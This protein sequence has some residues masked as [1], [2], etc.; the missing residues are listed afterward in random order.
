MT[1]VA[2]AAAALHGDLALG[3][4]LV[5]RARAAVGESLVEQPLDGL[6]VQVHALRLEE[7]TLVPLDPEPLQRADDFVDPR[8]GG[9]LAVGILD[10]K[11]ETAAEMASEKIAEERSAHATDVQ[12]AGR[13]RGEARS[14]GRHPGTANR[15]ASRVPTIEL[16]SAAGSPAEYA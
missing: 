2:Q 8:L 1:V 3:L 16:W 12:C 5:G 10:A 13:A 11:D 9:S 7:G 6:A 14:Y 15:A 4:E